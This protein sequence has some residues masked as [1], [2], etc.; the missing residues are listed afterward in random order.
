MS[1]ILFHLK[2]EPATS[3]MILIEKNKYLLSAKHCRDDS[4]FFL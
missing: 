3:S 1:R 4:E 2:I